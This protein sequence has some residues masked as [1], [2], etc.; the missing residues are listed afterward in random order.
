MSWLHGL[1]FLPVL[2]FLITPCMSLRHSGSV[3]PDNGSDLSLA[4]SSDDSKRRMQVVV[5]L[6]TA[7]GAAEWRQLIRQHWR[8]TSRDVTALGREVD[9]VM[10]FAVG[11]APGLLGNLMCRAEAAA[12]G[13]MAL[14]DV[15]DGIREEH[16]EMQHGGKIWYVFKW[17]V[18]NFPRADLYFKQDDDNIVNWRVALPTMLAHA[19]HPPKLPFERMYLGRL[20]LEF[21]HPCGM[22]ELYGFSKD[23]VMFGTTFTKP[24]VETEDVFT[25]N[26]VREMEKWIGEFQV[27]RGGLLSWPAYENAWVHPVKRK[28][29][30]HS[31]F[32]DLASGCLVPYPWGD[33]QNITF[34]LLPSVEAAR[35]W[36]AYNSTAT[37]EI[38][39]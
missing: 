25:C 39:F 29:V 9:L 37:Q 24:E 16:S 13:D 35:A 32:N 6:M 20:Q 2:V 18:D 11:K 8:E 4:N 33:H 31:C 3:A 12:H 21:G 1:R 5:M 28:E 22:G 34:R 30:Y 36:L 7:P 15:P 23:V 14:L 17:A 27:D 38:E 10:R 19:W 26:W